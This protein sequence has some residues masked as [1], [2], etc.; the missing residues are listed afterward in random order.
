MDCTIYCLQSG[1]F[2]FR[3][4]MLLSVLANCIKLGSNVNP[5]M[6]PY[7]RIDISICFSTALHNRKKINLPVS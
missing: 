2:D 5:R 4:L 6:S 1:S 7:T 3:W